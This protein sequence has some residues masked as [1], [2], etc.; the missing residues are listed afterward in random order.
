[1]KPIE[2]RHLFLLKRLVANLKF[3]EGF[4]KASAITA[5]ASADAS[6]E[7]L[8]PRASAYDISSNIASANT[9]RASA[10]HVGI[11]FI[12]FEVNYEHR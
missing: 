1:M 2:L 6:S 4:R 8:L 9:A 3:R 7:K 12:D 11:E 10:K 5:A